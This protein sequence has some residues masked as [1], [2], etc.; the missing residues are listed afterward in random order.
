[1]PQLRP[2]LLLALLTLACGHAAPRPAASPPAPIATPAAEATADAPTAPPTA[3]GSEAAD[4][5]ESETRPVA[6]ATAG[7]QQVT[8]DDDADPEPATQVQSAPKRPPMPRFKLFGTR[9][10][11]GPN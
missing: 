8:F 6:V 5:D 7:A 10:G 1:M 9:E 4:L 3:P 2:V 11:D